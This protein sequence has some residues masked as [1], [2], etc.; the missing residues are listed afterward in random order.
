MFWYFPEK[1]NLIFAESCTTYGEQDTFTVAFL[2]LDNYP[3][4]IITYDKD[5][6]EKPVASRLNPGDVDT[7]ET[8]F[9]Q[10]WLFKRSDTRQRLKAYANG[11]SSE[12]F[13][14]CRFKAN[15]GR[16]LRVN[17]SRGNERL[18]ISVIIFCLASM[19]FQ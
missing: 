10:D 7:H 12:T 5:G 11:V 4:D 1:S 6:N 14:G 9:T 3:I 15:K 2:N 18:K 19:F 13:E 17:I 8:H 16:L